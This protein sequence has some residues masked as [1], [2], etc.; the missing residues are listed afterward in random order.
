MRLRPHVNP[1][2]LVFQ[3]LRHDRLV[4]PEGAEV[5]VEIGCAEGLFLFARAAQDPRLFLVGIEIRE[6]LVHD[7]NRQAR[8][9][10]ARVRAEFAN[11]NVDFARMFAPATVARVHVNFPDPWFK[12][13]QHKRRV[14]DAALIADIAQ[15]LRPGGELIVQSDVFELVLEAMALVE[16]SPSFANRAGAWSFWKRGCPTG[17]RTRREEQ[18][19]DERASIW[20]LVYEKL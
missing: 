9:T 4:L 5:E 10:G 14:V 12:A 13:R 6:E 19:E 2:R 15:A 11:A 16:D 17:A 7:V 8:A 20:R 3:Q 18:C 1:L